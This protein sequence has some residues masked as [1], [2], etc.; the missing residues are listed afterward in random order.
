[1]VSP[2]RWQC[3]CCALPSHV[4]KHVASKTDD[5]ED[6]RRV[7]G[8]ARHSARLRA[9]RPGVAATAPRPAK[10]RALPK[11][12]RLV[13]DA[14]H[15]E[16][17]P[18]RLVRAEGGRAVRDRMVNDAYRNI[19]ITLDFYARVFKRSS[20][21]N[22]GM[23][24]RASV[25][26]RDRYPNAMWSGRE[27]LFGDGD[28]IGILGFAHCLDI[29][30]HELTHAVVQ[31]SV[32]GGLGDLDPSAKIVLGGQAGAL[33]E[34]FCD[35]FAS[36]VKQWHGQQNVGK[37]DWLVGV[38]VLAPGIGAAVRSLSDPGNDELTYSG[39]HQVKHMSGYVRRGSVHA[40]SG[41][42]SHAFYLAAT[43][44]GGYSWERVGQVWYRALQDL[45]SRSTF[46]QA[47]K[48]TIEQAG[49]LFGPSS[50]ERDAVLQGWQAVGVV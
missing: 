33:N 21:D 38:G 13:Y 8:H 2:I 25:H 29:V 48:A 4:L 17:V 41:I 24:V 14:Y 36:M 3:G 6:R 31:H 12:A 23:Q 47:A 30:A 34:S 10:S 18:G 40:N 39:D 46:R 20:L 32:R 15:S 49:K 16:D 45:H 11:G 43:A 22:R 42:A 35:V 28:G 37:A 26:Y 27:M 44:L 50:K 1:M 9:E 5:P 19:G 7:L